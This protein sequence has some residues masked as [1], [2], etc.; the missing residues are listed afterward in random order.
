[1]RKTHICTFLAAGAVTAAVLVSG[2]ALA[3]YS[4]K[5]AVACMTFG[6]TPV[7][8][9]NVIQNAAAASEL[10]LL[11]D[12]PD[13][14]A[15]PGHTIAQVH[16]YGFDGNNAGVNPS[17]RNCSAGNLPSFSCAGAVTTVGATGQFDLVPPIPGSWNAIGGEYRYTQVTIPRSGGVNSYLRGVFVA[18]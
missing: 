11:C 6:G 12:A 7:N 8:V 5:H 15:M 14:T 2:P 3:G 18:D 10:T 13:D 16:A 1:M 4:N 9:D 17:V